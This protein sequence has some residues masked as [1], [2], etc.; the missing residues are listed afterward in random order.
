MILQMPAS[1]LIPMVVSLLVAGNF[2]T[3]KKVRVNN[4]LSR[5]YVKTC[6]RH[7]TFVVFRSISD[8]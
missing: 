7:D 4:G 6:D 5:L 1:I 3:A 8:I 2:E